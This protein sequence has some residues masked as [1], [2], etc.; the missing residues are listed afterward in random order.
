MRAKLEDFEIP[1]KLL[2]SINIGTAGAVHIKGQAIKESDRKLISQGVGRLK[3]G[4]IVH[5]DAADP[6]GNKVDGAAEVKNL[7]L[8]EASVNY[9]VKLSFTLSLKVR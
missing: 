3:V 9:Y 7:D 4:E 8:R 5:L 6:Y 2:G 1:E